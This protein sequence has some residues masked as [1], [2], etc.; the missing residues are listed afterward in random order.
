MIYRRPNLHM[1][2]NLK[3]KSLGFKNAKYNYLHY[4][5]FIEINKNSVA[6]LPRKRFV[7]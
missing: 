1:H 3:I 6:S 2:D 4:K 7:K 5:T